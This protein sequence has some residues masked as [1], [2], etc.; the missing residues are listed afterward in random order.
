MRCASSFWTKL[1]TFCY[2]LD[3][4]SSSVRLVSHRSTFSLVILMLSTNTSRLPTTTWS[5]WLRRRWALILSQGYFSASIPWQSTQS[6]YAFVSFI[7]IYF[8]LFLNLMFNFFLHQQFK[9][10]RKTT[11]HPINPTTC[12]RTS[13]KF[14]AKRTKSK[15]WI[16]NVCIFFCC[17]FYQ[18]FKYCLKVIIELLVPYIV[19]LAHFLPY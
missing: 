14:L 6:F 17:F 8:F 11:A 10:P 18:W 9:I 5:R 1:Q 16:F 4:W 15:Q 19:M 13:W 3:A 12:P 7:F 2:F